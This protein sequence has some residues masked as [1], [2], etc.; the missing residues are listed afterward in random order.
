MR[1]NSPQIYH[2]VKSLKMLNDAFPIKK[3]FRR[4]VERKIESDTLE[5]E[6]REK[7]KSLNDIEEVRSTRGR[8]RMRRKS[9]R[10]ATATGAA[11]KKAGKGE[12]ELLAAT[13]LVKYD[14]DMQSSMQWTMKYAPQMAEDVIGNQGV[15]KKLQSWLEE[16]TE[17]QKRRR[18]NK[19]KRSHH[20]SSDEDSDESSWDSYVEDEFDSSSEADQ[21]QLLLANTA[22][23]VG[24]SGVG[25]TSTVYALATQMGFKVLEV[26]ASSLRGGRQVM[27]RLQE[28]TQSHHVVKNNSNS[29]NSGS[30]STSSKKGSS[31]SKS[32]NNVL[33]KNKSNLDKTALILFEDID[34]VFEDQD[35]GFYS[36]VS[37]LIA[38]TKR[39]IVLT[40]SNANFYPRKYLKTEPQSFVFKPVAAKLSAQ[41]IQLLALAE[42]FPIHSDAL[43]ALILS[44]I[45]I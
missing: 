15:V 33:M 28:A 41:Y 35:D 4:Y 34:V 20:H 11:T 13:Q 29:N 10:E 40:T 31:N 18:Q 9:K 1:M 21:S 27:S 32:H 16:W 22:M 25:K 37:G 19:K 38:T 6:A 30:T 14:P 43:A 3:I 17:R 45:H 42:G 2:F 5:T 39:P 23:L 8:R 36:A 44:L 24:P 26:N 7:N 12:K